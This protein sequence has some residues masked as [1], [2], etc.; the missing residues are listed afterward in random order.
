MLVIGIAGGIASGKS[1]VADCFERLGAVV[2]SADKIGHRVLDQLD[3]KEK[4]LE[5]WG[6]EVFNEGQVDRAALGRAVFGSAD[7]EHQLA[8]LEQITHPMIGQRIVERLAALESS[9]VPA[10]VLDAPVMFYH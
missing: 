8:K 9:G 7:A 5:N 1:S 6:G 10:V 2:L 4:I 3:V